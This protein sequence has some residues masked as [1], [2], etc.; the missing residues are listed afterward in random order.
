M[1]IEL[2]PILFIALAIVFFVFLYSQ[3]GKRKKKIE[4]PLAYKKRQQLFTPSESTFLYALDKA[5]GK[6]FRVFGKVRLADI[7][8]T[9][10]YRGVGDKAFSLIAFK[11]IDFL[12]CDCRSLSILCAIELDDW[13][14]QNEKRQVKDAE[15]EF[16]LH[17]AGIP[18]IRFTVDSSYK[19]REIRAKILGKTNHK[20]TDLMV[21]E[22]ICP[23]C[24]AETIARLAKTGIHKGKLFIG[25][26]N[27]PD[28]R[29][30]KE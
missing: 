8:D 23:K 9:E 12:L 27:Y 10:V 17:S 29:F 11:H 25:C 30:I 22:L 24:G 16:A 15:K 2:L 13:T 19:L 28:C 3:F 5:V 21:P 14:H 1:T 7:V 4:I 26:S 20:V 18:L 6:D